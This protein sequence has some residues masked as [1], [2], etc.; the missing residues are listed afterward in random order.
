MQAARGV[1]I[2]SGLLFITIISNFEEYH[3]IPTSRS[4]TSKDQWRDRC[5][6]VLIFIIS[7][8]C[9]EQTINKLCDGN[10]ICLPASLTLKPI[11]FYQLHNSFA[12]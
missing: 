8:I 9:V 3:E 1:Y 6:K 10:S 4:F 7:S 12:L 11:Y 2:Y 5:S